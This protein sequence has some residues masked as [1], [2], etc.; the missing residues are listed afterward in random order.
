MGETSGESVD[1]D[2]SFE[3]AWLAVSCM[4]RQLM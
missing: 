1:K 4:I 2:D 3:M